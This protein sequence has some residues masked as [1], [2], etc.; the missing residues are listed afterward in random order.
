MLVHN[1]LARV[2]ACIQQVNGYPVLFDIIVATPNQ[3]SCGVKHS[4]CIVQ[5]CPS[6]KHLMHVLLNRSGTRNIVF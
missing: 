1:F 2:C 5:G 4:A 3:V 6:A